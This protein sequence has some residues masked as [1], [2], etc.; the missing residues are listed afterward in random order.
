MVA[1]NIVHEEETAGEIKYITVS[2]T[3]KPDGSKVVE[4]KVGFRKKTKDK[5]DLEQDV[6]ELK[7]GYR[8]LREDV[9][10]MKE[11]SER[12]LE[13]ITDGV[14]QLHAL[15]DVRSLSSKRDPKQ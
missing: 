5:E 15:S 12:A 1:E 7:Q 10:S 11:K 8:E 4:R 2:E 9:D 3:T 6:E 13:M 14:K